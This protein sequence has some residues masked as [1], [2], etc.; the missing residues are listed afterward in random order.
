MEMIK[1]LIKEF[2]LL[3]IVLACVLFV[4]GT[5]F[6]HSMFGKNTVFQ[7]VGGVLN[8]VIDSGVVK[9]D[10]IAY[11]ED[12]VSDYMPEIK[13]VGGIQSD[14][15][16]IYFKE[17]F[18]VKLEDGTVVSGNEEDGFAI[19]LLD[20][21]NQLGQSVFL[22]L[23]ADEIADMTEIPA[24]FVYD[25]EGDILCC[26]QDGIYTIYLKIYGANGGQEIFEF[27][28]PVEVN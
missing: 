15:S 9:T 12:I 25:K 7:S 24:S 11:V 22:T 28:F 14:G 1:N 19:C 10:G 20:I 6:L 23:T 3:L 13:Y 26:F 2:Y 8:P 16:Y 18:T 17:Q 5:F 21:K 4:V 27:Q